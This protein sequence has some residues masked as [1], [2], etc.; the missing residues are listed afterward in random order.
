MPDDPLVGFQR[1]KDRVGED[2]DGVGE[3]GEGPALVLE[4]LGG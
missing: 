2:A 1:N 3:R 4:P